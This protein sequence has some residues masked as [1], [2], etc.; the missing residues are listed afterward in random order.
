MSLGQANGPDVDL[1]SAAWRGVPPVRLRRYPTPLDAG[2]LSTIAI[3]EPDGVVGVD[4]ERTYV[5]NLRV[6]LISP[7][8][9]SVVLHGQLGEPDDNLV[10]TVDSA[11]SERSAA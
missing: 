7:A 8:G 10:T 5:G 3:T 9:P 11:L 2:I 1:S 6:T 4:I